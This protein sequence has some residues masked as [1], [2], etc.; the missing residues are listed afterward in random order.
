MAK[1][2]YLSTTSRLLD[3]IVSVAVKGPS[4]AG[5][6]I[7][8]ERTLEFF[9]ENA[10]HALTAMSERGLI[11]I[12]ESMKHRMLVMFE[13]AG[14]AGD[15]QS[16]LLRSLLSEGRIRY[17][18]P[19]KVEGEIKGRLIELEGPTGLIVTTTAISLHPENETRLLSVT[20][21]DTQEQTRRVFAALANEEEIPSISTRGTLSS[22]GSS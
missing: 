2:I 20:A 21:T 22:A 17:Q 16:Y 11:F 5:K 13:A 19:S 8:V 6:S 15:L 14:M 1:L 18:M 12:E 7:V 9:P 4:S 3:K 10:T